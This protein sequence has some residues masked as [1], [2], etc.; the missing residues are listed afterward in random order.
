MIKCSNCGNELKEGTKFCSKCGNNILEQEEKNCNEILNEERQFVKECVNCGS[1]LKE[2]AKFCSKCGSSVLEQKEDIDVSKDEEVNNTEQFKKIFYF[3][4]IKMLGRLRYKIIRTEVRNSEDSLQ[5]KQNIHRFLRKNKENH[6][7]IKLSEIDSMKVKTKM[8][9]WDTLYAA[10]F[11]V[12]FLLDM[13][14]IVWLFLIAIFLYTGYGKILNLRMRNGLTFEIPVNG[15]T[16]D[17]EK[18]QALIGKE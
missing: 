11:G 13:T 8:D 7:E 4:K 3:Q 5:I 12:M 16:E 2:E 18:F 14:D 10:L 6:L 15:M 9:F 1:E 17:V